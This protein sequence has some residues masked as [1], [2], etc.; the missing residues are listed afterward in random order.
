MDLIER[1]ERC[2]RCGC[3]DAMHSHG[4]YSR[5]VDDLLIYIVRFRCI[6]CALD[7]SVLPGFAMPYVN[8]S[9]KR[10]DAFIT[11]S[12]A[13]RSDKGDQDT[14]RR[15]VKRWQASCERIMRITG[16]VAVDARAAW[17]ALKVRYGSI[18][19]A[20]L[21]LIQEAGQALLGCYSI[22]RRQT[23]RRGASS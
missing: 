1:P 3:V 10:I 9:I 7:V 8:R 23:E 17:E 21:W 14:M 20:Q 6:H 13:E 19:T 12:D 16:L 4:R 5:Y 18:E 15:Y 11:A 2:P 22:H